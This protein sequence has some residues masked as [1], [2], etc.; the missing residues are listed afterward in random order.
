MN[1]IQY[2]SAEIY[3]YS[4]DNY[5]EKVEMRHV[6]FTKYMP[7]TIKIL[8]KA[9]L[10]PISDADLAKKLEIE[11]DKI[12]EWKEVYKSAKMVVDAGNAGDSFK[13][14][15]KETVKNFVEEEKMNEE[16][17]NEL[18]EQILYRTADFGFLL[19]RENKE[20]SDYSEMFRFG[21]MDFD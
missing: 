18:V 13:I 7:Q 15:I 19:K 3:G 14:G 9:E 16:K 17:I 21:D 6:R 2:L 12:E 8:E 11:I 4:Y 20:I 5:Q 1:R 10:K